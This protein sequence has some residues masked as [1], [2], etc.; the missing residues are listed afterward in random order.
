MGRQRD[1]PGNGAER[2]IRSVRHRDD[3]KLKVEGSQLKVIE[4]DEQVELK[5]KQQV[6]KNN[7]KAKRI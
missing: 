3:N 1:R 7:L 2:P 6:E 4:V 5:R